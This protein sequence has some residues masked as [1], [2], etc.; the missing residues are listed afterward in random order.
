MKNRMILKNTLKSYI[1]FFFI[2]IIVGIICRLTDFLPNDALWNFSSIATLYG[3][4]ICSIVVIVSYSFSNI[5]AGFNTFLYMFGMTISF[6]LLQYILGFYIPRFDNGSFKTDLFFIYS[7]LA[8]IC[9]I[10]GFVLYFW[11]KNNK[12]SS[13]LYALPIG[14]LLAEAIGVAIYLIANKTYLFQLLF[15]IISASI[16]GILFYRKSNNKAIYC[17][18]MI[19]VTAMVYMVIYMPF[20]N[21]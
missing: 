2:G 19:I 18:T 7:V 6:Y 12:F 17:I 21:I 10:G 16:L 13:I 14:A 15:N 3:F 11:N 5:S 20:L 9:G 1:L 8:V 4:W